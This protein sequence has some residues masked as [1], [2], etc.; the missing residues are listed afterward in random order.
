MDIDRYK[1]GVIFK[2]INKNEIYA[3]YNASFRGNSK[4]L[5]SMSFNIFNLFEILCHFVCPVIISRPPP[6]I[7]LAL[8]FPFLLSVQP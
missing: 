2:W 6:P 7:F 5:F 4:L 8:C 1:G 3:K